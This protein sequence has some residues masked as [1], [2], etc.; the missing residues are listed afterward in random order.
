MAMKPASLARTV[1]EKQDDAKSWSERTEEDIPDY[2]WGTI[3]T[4]EHEELQKVGYSRGQLEAGDVVNLV[5][6]AMVVSADAKQ[7]NGGVRYSIR[8]QITDLGIEKK[9]EQP[10]QATVLFGG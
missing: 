10:A 1:K 7:V 6:A 2:P 5:G 8:L 3:I 4:L 9:E